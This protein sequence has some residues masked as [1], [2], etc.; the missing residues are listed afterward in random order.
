[1]CLLSSKRCDLR[2]LFFSGDD[3]FIGDI[4]QRY[5]GGQGNECQNHIA[6]NDTAKISD[7]V[8]HYVE[9]G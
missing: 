4:Q 3:L 1:V 9:L 8:V 7:I 5:I 6:N 2:D